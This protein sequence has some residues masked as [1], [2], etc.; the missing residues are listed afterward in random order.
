MFGIVLL[1]TPSGPPP[2]QGTGPTHFRVAVAPDAASGGDAS[3]PG[4][5]RVLVVPI[6][7]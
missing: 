1:L 2:D 4:I 5:A 7:Q 3:S 6:T